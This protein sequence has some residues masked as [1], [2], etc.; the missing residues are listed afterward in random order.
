MQIKLSVLSVILGLVVLLPNVYG[1][2][3]PKEFGETARAFPRSGN[4]GWVLMLLGTAWFVYYVR[5]ER[6]ADFENLKPYLYALFITI[7]VGTCYFVQDFLAVRGLAVVM[8][9]LAKVMVDTA[10]W[11]TSQ[12]SLIITTWA[13]VLAFAGMW[14]TISPWRLRDLIGWATGTEQRVR[15]G[16]GLRAA[17]GALV[18][19]LGLFVF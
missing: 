1:M 9:L 15:I 10:R 5:Q 4:A 2:L 13:Y 18:A 17:F 8:L 19:L 3:K 14:F 6:I 16:C 7:G 12:W 11:S